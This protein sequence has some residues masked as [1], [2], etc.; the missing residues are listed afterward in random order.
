MQLVNWW[1]QKSVR[2]PV[3][4]CEKG[5]DGAVVRIFG[6]AQLEIS[7]S[8]QPTSQFSTHPCAQLSARS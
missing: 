4:G 1:T 5:D 3:G 8:I 2:M 6:D 7:C